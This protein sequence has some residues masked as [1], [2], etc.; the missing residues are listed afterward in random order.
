MSR[1][2]G[3]PWRYRLNWILRVEKTPG[4]A[5]LNFGKRPATKTS[6]AGYMKSRIQNAPGVGMSCFPNHRKFS[7]RD[8]LSFVAQ[9][10]P[11]GCGCQARLVKAL[12]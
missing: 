8:K 4:S 9:C 7:I 5:L 11:Q 10:P 3:K 2:E 6:A 1:P 12:S